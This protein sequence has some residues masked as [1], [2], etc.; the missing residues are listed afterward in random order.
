MAY[1]QADFAVSG[2]MYGGGTSH[3]MGL[4]DGRCPSLC[5]PEGRCVGWFN[6]CKGLIE[7]RKDIC[8]LC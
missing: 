3:A 4:K 7:L 8:D 6:S 1:R 5:S 2:L